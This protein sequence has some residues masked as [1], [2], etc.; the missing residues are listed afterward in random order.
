MTEEEGLVSPL[1]VP[2]SGAWLLR[3]QEGGTH[4]ADVRID[5]LYAP[6]RALDKQ[7]RVHELLDG[8]DDAV[9]GAD[10]DG[11]SGERGDETS[12]R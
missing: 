4:H 7:L 6:V 12:A 10:A 11:G 3:A 2:V 5:R 1:A 9:L 8:E